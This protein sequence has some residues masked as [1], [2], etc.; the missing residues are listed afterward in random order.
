MGAIDGDADVKAPALKDLTSDNITENVVLM[1]SSG[2]DARLSY[3]LE[4][5]THHLHEFARETRL[6]TPEWMA[7]LQFLTEVGKTT[8]DVRNVWISCSTP[9]SVSLRFLRLILSILMEPGMYSLI[10]HLRIFHAY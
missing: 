2:S 4:R 3:I 5:L 7:G 1:N 9:F 8:T 6:S 10:R